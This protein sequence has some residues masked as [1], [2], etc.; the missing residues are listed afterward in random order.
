MSAGDAVAT[1]IDRPATGSRGAIASIN[2]SFPGGVPKRPIDR[3]RITVSGLVGDGQRTKAPVHGGPEKAVC[4]YGLEQIRRVNADG[5]H[6]YPGA[7]GE[8]LTIVGLELGAN[9]YIVKP[10]FVRELIARIKIHFRGQQ[11]PPKILKAGDLEVDGERCQVKLAG[12]EVV[13]TATEFRLLDYLVRH[14]GR[15]FTRDQL[16]DAGVGTIDGVVRAVEGLSFQVDA[17]ETVAIVGE[18]GCGKSVT[19]MSILRLIQEPPGKIKGSIR[20]QG[21]ELLSLSEAEMRDIRGNSISMI[22]QDPMTSLNPFLRV[23]AQLMEVTQ[24][25]LRHGRDEARAHALQML[26]RVGIPDAAR[27]M[28]AYPHELSGGMRQRVVLARAL[29]QNASVLLMDEP[30]AA[31]DPQ[32][33]LLMGEE[34]LQLWRQSR[35]SVLLITHSLEEAVMLSDRVLVMSAR[36]GLLRHELVTGWPSDRGAEITAQANFSARGYRRGIVVGIP[37][38]V[39]RT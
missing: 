38:S 27:R 26:E 25:H 15:V 16:L 33:R 8:N 1:K 20:F 19:S 34:L 23:S 21:R 17:G 31:L 28:D 13:L 18:S 30:F 3:T 35:A 32:T 4:L 24:L 14:A 2:V 5:H 7:I 11:A 9:D 10:F 37:R 12:H 39:R 22:F 36:P 29:A 6:L